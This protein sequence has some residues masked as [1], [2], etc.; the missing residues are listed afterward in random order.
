[1]MLDLTYR[2]LLHILFYYFKILILICETIKQ[3][4]VSMSN[5]NPLPMLKEGLHHLK[6]D[7]W[8]KQI[9]YL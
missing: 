7:I 9:L 2:H 8:Q 1:M 4:K 3:N 5:T 6:L